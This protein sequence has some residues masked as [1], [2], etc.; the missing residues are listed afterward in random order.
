MYNESMRGF[1]LAVLA[2]VGSVASAYSFAGSDW[3]FSMDAVLSIRTA[4]MNDDVP[5]NSNDLVTVTSRT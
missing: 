4:V 3:T 1:A 2:G 5:V